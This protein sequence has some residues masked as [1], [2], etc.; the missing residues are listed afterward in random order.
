M[1]K[2]AS[3]ASGGGDLGAMLPFLKARLRLWR[4]LVVGTADGN[5]MTAMVGVRS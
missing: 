4:P 1:S 5:G 2:P 3:R